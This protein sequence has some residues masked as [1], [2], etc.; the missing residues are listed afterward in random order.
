LKEK[1]DTLYFFYTYL[2]SSLFLLLIFNFFMVLLDSVGLTMFVPLLQVADGNESFGA[3][4]GKLIEVVESFFGIFH[5]SVTVINMLILIALIFSLKALF[6]YYVQKYTVV[7][8]Q[9]MSQKIRTNL[10]Y[11]LK[12][13]SYREFVMADIGR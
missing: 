2:R 12:N 3:E 11:G 4:N 1:F 9:V 6:V 5:L 8:M 13:L 7:T 10:A